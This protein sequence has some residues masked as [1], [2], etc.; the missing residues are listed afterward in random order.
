MQTGNTIRYGNYPGKTI[1]LIRIRENTINFL[2]TKGQFFWIDFGLYD[3]NCDSS[4][5]LWLW[6]GQIIS[7]ENSL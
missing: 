1:D 7:G 4:L 3:V 5:R 2:G 6:S